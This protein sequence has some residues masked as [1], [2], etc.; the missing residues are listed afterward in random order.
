V[1][2]LGDGACEGTALQAT[3]HE[4]GGC[5][6]CRTAQSTVATWDGETLRL[7]TWGA[8]SQPGPLMA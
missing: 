2:C 7:D 3:R 4:A 1:V 5:E 6:A 8:W